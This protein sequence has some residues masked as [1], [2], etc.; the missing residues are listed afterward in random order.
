MK[1]S[2]SLYAWQRTVTADFTSRESYVHI[3]F[4]VNK[5]RIGFRNRYTCKHYIPGNGKC[6]EFCSK[7]P[8]ICE[9]TMIPDDVDQGN[10]ICPSDHK[11]DRADMRSCLHALFSVAGC[12]K[13]VYIQADRIRVSGSLVDNGEKWPL[14]TASDSAAPAD[15]G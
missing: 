7:C 5:N 11:D 12:S 14:G 2:C 15:R 3:S 4:H 9:K 13:S 6:S 8:T 1:S 10:L